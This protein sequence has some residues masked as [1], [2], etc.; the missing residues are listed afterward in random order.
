MSHDAL[1]QP[2]SEGTQK[3]RLVFSHSIPRPYTQGG[4]AV[5]P[6]IYQDVIGVVGKI[7]VHY[8]PPEDGFGS[9]ESDVTG[10]DCAPAL[11]SKLQKVL[12]RHDIEVFHAG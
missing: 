2:L 9:F 12:K 3:V 7:D 1:G 5:V 6:A 8:G 4:K 10:C 11:V